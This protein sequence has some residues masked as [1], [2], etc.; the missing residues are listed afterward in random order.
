MMNQLVI[1]ND[2]RLFYGSHP[3]QVSGHSH[4]VI[5]WV[6]AV[7]GTFLSKDT[8]KGWTPKKGLL[9]APNHYH[10][11]NAEEVP[12]I[13]VDIDPTSQLGEWIMAHQLKNQE[14][15]DYPSQQLEKMDFDTFLDL[16][17][18]SNWSGIRDLME[19]SLRFPKNFKKA[20]TDDR[21]QRIMEFIA[22]NIDTDIT[23]KTLAEVAFLSESRT[24]HLFKGDFLFGIIFSGIGLE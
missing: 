9:I 14:L 21:I 23:T 2:M 10:E 1:W 15:I 24:I 6:M 12:I 17:E 20:Q 3:R 22:Q 19:R 18:K 7:K 8:G 13:S 16:F 11:C 5:Q 4:P